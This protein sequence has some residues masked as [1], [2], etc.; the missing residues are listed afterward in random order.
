[1]LTRRQTL[2]VVVLAVVDLLVI[3]GIVAFAWTRHEP[4][5]AFQQIAFGE[6]NSS[7]ECVAFL[8]DSAGKA[9]WTGRV[10]E[11][12]SVLVYEVSMGS[13]AYA[14]E[15]SEAI[16]AVLDSLS[17]E[18]PI[19]CGTPETLTIIAVSGVEGARQ[20]VTAQFSG[21]ALVDWLQGLSSDSDLALSSR[22]R[23]SSE[24]S[25]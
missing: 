12:E 3:A 7:S 2:T 14:L 11:T 23:S 19:R 16:W 5:P 20:Q 17:P 8:L 22:F 25:P 9:G 4:T 6:V 24:G 18:F 15:D 13:T 10:S 1:M 21:D